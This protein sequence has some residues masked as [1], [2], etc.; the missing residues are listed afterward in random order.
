MKSFFKMVFASMVGMILS[1]FVIFILLFVMVAAIV[2]SM[3]NEKVKVEDNSV[4]NMSLDHPIHERSSKNPFD[5]LDFG[6]LEKNK[7]IG[8]NDIL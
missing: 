1:F 3:D 8:L 4:I 2:A 6:G 7:S 5:K